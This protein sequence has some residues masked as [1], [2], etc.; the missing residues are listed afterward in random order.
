MNPTSESVNS[1]LGLRLFAIYTTFYAAYVFVNAFAASWA[2]WTP[3]GGLNLAVLWGFSL[4]GLAFILAMVYG[5]MCTDDAT[6][7]QDDASSPA[8]DQ[9]AS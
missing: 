4:I 6:S 8:N 5:F 7:E 1:R 3:F 2:E 9:E